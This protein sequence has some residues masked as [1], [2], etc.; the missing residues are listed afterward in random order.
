MEHR[1]TCKVYYEDTD[2]LGVVYHT[3]Y[4]KYM[5]R[6]RSE[7]VERFGKPIWEWNQSGYYIVVY[8]M[9]IRFKNALRNSAT[10]SK[11][12]PHFNLQSP[13]RGSVQAAHRARWT[14]LCRSRG[15]TCVPRPALQSARVSAGVSFVRHRYCTPIR[16]NTS[17]RVRCNPGG[18]CP[19][20][21]DCRSSASNTR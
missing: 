3:N 5:E 4:L 20:G 8:A 15:R 12:C 17:S 13:Y 19:G 18:R 6:G 2:A 11:L 7:Y 9:N 14:D 21:Y 16:R 10:S 1:L